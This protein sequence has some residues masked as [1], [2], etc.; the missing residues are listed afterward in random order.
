MVLFLFCFLLCLE[1][2]ENLMLETWLPNS[3]PA[4]HA[5][6]GSFACFPWRAKNEMENCNQKN[7]F[8]LLDTSSR[9]PAGDD[10]ELSFLFLCPPR[11]HIKKTGNT[12]LYG[13]PMG[14]DSDSGWSQT[15]GTCD[16]RD[17][18][19][20][21]WGTVAISVIWISIRAFHSGSTIFIPSQTRNTCCTTLRFVDWNFFWKF[22]H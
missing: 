3:E 16:R 18:Q 17:A 15:T 12:S 14:S 6:A 10:S 1:L 9:C 19:H 7:S 13:T 5:L 11:P 8:S 20:G 2:Q 4:A 21:F 22:F